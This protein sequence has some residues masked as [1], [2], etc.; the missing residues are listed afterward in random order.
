MADSNPI[1][2]FNIQKIVTEQFAISGEMPNENSKLNFI[3]N[4]E[5][6]P[7]LLTKTITVF[8]KFNFEEANKSFLVVE[9]SCQFGVHP[10]D[11]E[12][13]I[14][15]NEALLK[16]PKGFL[17]HLAMLTV[18]TTRGILHAKTESTPFNRFFIPPVNLTI[19]IKEDFVL[20]L[21]EIKA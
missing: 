9:G 14:N 2:R 12:T 3:S 21:G 4:I 19:L 15:K 17:T 10:D 20:N 7:S 11:W 5:F 18:G 13:F 1:I 16:I 6:K 8:S